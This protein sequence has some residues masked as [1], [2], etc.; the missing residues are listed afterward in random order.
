M[1]I[2]ILGFRWGLR[3]AYK[4]SWAAGLAAFQP[5]PGLRHASDAAFA[6]KRLRVSSMLVALR[7]FDCSHSGVFVASW[8]TQGCAPPKD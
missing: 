5:A 6:V 3:R 7:L 1:Y 2:C 4:R 8:R